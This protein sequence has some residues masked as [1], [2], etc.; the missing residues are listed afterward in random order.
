MRKSQKPPAE[1]FGRRFNTQAGSTGWHC[2]G[3]LAPWCRLFFCH[4]NKLLHLPMDV[5]TGCLVAL[6]RIINASER[7]GAERFAAAAVPA[8][9]DATEFANL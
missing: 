5:P 7:G 3:G 6:H 4:K 8:Q 1:P 2:P 9:V